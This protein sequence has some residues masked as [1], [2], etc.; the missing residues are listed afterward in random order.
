MNSSL[1]TLAALWLVFAASV[2]LPSPCMAD[3]PVT[4]R[5][6][7]ELDR[8]VVKLSDLFNGVPEEIDRDI[9]LA[10]PPGKQAIYDTNLLAKLADRYRLDWHVGEGIDHD[11]IVSD[12]SRI[13]T[14]AITASLVDKIKEIEAKGSVSIAFDGRAPVVDLP[15]HQSTAF[16]LNNFDY[17]PGSKRFHTDLIAE[18]GQG[19]IS[20]PLSG[21]AILKIRVPTLTHWL[22]GGAIIGMTD[23]DWLEIPAERIN[24]GVVTDATQLI[25]RE[26]RHPVSEGEILRTSDILPPRMVKRGSL[27]SM[28]IQTAFMVVT[29]QGKALQDGTL[30]EV[31]RVLNT[32][33]NRTIEGTVTGPDT[34]T[35]PTAQ[36]LASAAH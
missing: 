5:G 36:K 9:A 1:R 21:H 28:K 24:D 34:V 6:Q 22:D 31:V 30:G 23:I 16:S 29:A 8:G 26:L 7:V 19:Q 17:D 3:N 25:N 15:A 12:Y 20:V 10:P 18:S 35:V 4:A 27:I 2:G 14:D 13:T 32:Q 11:T 33:S